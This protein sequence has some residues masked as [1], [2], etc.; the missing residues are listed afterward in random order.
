MQYF[1]GSGR[2]LWCSFSS[3][4][5][6]CYFLIVGNNQQ[7]L[8]RNETEDCESLKKQIN[9][10]PSTEKKIN[11]GR[12]EETLCCTKEEITSSEQEDAFRKKKPQEKKEGNVPN[13]NWNRNRT[14]R[15]N[16]KKNV[17]ISTRVSEQSELKYLCNEYERLDLRENIG[18]RAW[19]PQGDGENCKADQK[20]GSLSIQ[21]ETESFYQ[22][23]K[24]NCLEKFCSDSSSDC[25]S[26]SGSVRA[27]RGSWGSW[28]STSSSDGDKKPMI[29]ARHFLPSRE[30]ISQNDFPSETPITLNLSHNIC[31]TSRDMNSIPQYPDTLCPNFT[32]IAADPEK[33]KGLYPAGDLW[34]PQPV[35]LTN[36]LNYNL[37]NNLPCMIQETPPIHNRYLP[38]VQVISCHPK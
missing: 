13:M 20:P 19:R 31:N 28:S 37:E 10:K 17:N 36:S 24:K 6:S 26:S 27:S 3:R 4:A 15:K 25:G 9:I 23:S 33:N 34:P 16:K 8:L 14:S 38:S 2:G 7:A 18:I 21:G 12:K 22:W 35:C 32:D 30:N 1:Q 5:N 11:K 29:T